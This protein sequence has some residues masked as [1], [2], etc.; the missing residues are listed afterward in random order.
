MHRKVW[1]KVYKDETI[2]KDLYRGFDKWLHTYGREI[3]VSKTS[4]KSLHLV[5]AR[6]IAKDNTNNT[7]GLEAETDKVESIDGSNDD[8]EDGYFSDKGN[9]TLSI[10]FAKDDMEMMKRSG[11]KDSNSTTYDR[12]DPANEMRKRQDGSRDE[13]DGDEVNSNSERRKNKVS[14][15]EG[16]EE[17]QGGNNDDSVVGRGR[18]V[19]RENGVDSPAKNTRGCRGKIN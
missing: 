3:I 18:R 2:I 11:V 7:H 17:S 19:N 14:R 8:E 6:W 15:V 1:R 16:R 9:N 4:S 5:L 10:I 13:R 12:F